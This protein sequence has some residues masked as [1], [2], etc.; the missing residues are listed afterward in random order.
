MVAFLDTNNEILEKEYKNTIHFKITH[1]I[2]KY[3][4]INLNREMKDLYAENYKALIKVIRE[5]SKK[6]KI[7]HTPGLKN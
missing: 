2:I 1:P 3:L 4:G 6:W 7:F 5:D